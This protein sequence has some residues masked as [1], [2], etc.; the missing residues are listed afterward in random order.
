MQKVTS[1]RDRARSALRAATVPLAIGGAIFAA[2]GSWVGS[3]LAWG[4]CSVC[5]A[6]YSW[7]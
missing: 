6:L 3:A 1:R 4:A 5:W 7:R 2:A